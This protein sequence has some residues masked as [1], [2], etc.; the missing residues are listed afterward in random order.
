MCLLF[1]HFSERENNTVNLDV[2]DENELIEIIKKNHS[3]L[4]ENLIERI[5]KF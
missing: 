3:T 4:L 1:S 2:I 5:L